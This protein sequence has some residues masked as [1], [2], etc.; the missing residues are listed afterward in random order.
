MVDRKYYAL[1]VDTVTG[2]VM[3]E[4][5]LMAEPTWTQQINQ[6]GSWQITTPLGN[7]T[8]L[9][10][11]LPTALLR[12]A[13]SKGR[14]SVA[15]CYGDGSLNDPIVQAGPIW[16]DAS[17]DGAANNTQPSL[18]LGG[19]GLWSALTA[20]LTVG[21]SWTPSAG[22][23]ATS[24]NVTYTS[25]LQG[26]ASMMLTD[27]VTRGALPID[28]PTPITPTTTPITMAYY[29]YDMKMVGD[30]LRDLTQ[31]AG[32][33]TADLTS[34]GA[35]T[36]PDILFQPYFSDGSHV[37]WKALIGTP[38]LTQSGKSINF[39][40]G[41]NLQSVTTANDGSK[42]ATTQYEKGSG[43]QASLLWAYAQDSTLTNL[44][45]PL[46]E[47]VSTAHSDVVDQTTLQK[48]A[49]AELALYGRPVETWS[50]VVRADMLPVLGTYYAGFYANYNMINHPWIPDGV[51]QQRILG[52]SNGQN[53]GEIIH[54]L[55]ATSGLV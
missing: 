20:R 34:L 52:I 26:I 23:A 5:P 51:Y 46:L 40:Y 18:T 47:S 19:A 32:L 6:P 13:V 39:D 48:W 43:Q 33:T 54:V 7:P 37:R 16:T 14:I 55:Q 24:A 29:G 1:A 41:A 17:D 28:I 15:I 38:T 9:A 4:L 22:L 31:L 35:T 27:T 12:A 45:W 3:Q 2:H 50:G 25:S 36:G 49:N 44:G 10:S 42:L 53:P 30:N 11:G 21:P 8:D